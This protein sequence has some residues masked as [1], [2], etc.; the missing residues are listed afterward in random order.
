RPGHVQRVAA[1]P[2]APCRGRRADLGKEG[3]CATALS[4]KAAAG[5]RS[6]QRRAIQLSEEKNIALAKRYGVSRKT[7]AKWKAR[8]STSDERMGRKKFL[9]VRSHSERR[10]DHSRLPLAHP[11]PAQR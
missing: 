2:R 4:G 6:M 5:L 11:P 9:L 8:E 7:I 3:T 1:V 10:S